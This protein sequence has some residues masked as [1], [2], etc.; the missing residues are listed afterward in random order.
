MRIEGVRAFGRRHGF[1]MHM[2]VRHEAG[3]ELVEVNWSRQSV[4]W[5]A[6]SGINDFSNG[7]GGGAEPSALSTTCQL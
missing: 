7:D 3:L 1:G 4:G 6:A 5:I 2:S